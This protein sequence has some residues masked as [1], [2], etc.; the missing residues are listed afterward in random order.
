MYAASRPVNKYQQ[1]PVARL[2]DGG[3]P[4]GEVSERSTHLPWMKLFTALA[5]L[6]R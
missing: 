5:A 2:A 6:G 3:R 1:Y 4:L